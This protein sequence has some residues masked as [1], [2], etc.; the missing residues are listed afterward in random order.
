MRVELLGPVRAF[1]GA[2][3]VVLGPARQRAVFAALAVRAGRPVP[4]GD[5]VEA[6]WGPGAPASAAGGVHGY[7][8]RLRR[9]LEP[10]RAPR[11]TGTLLT[12]GP[13]GYTL[14]LAPAQIDAT[15][16]ERLIERARQDGQTVAW[17]DKALG[18]WHGEP[19]AGVP[20]PLAETERARLGEL[21]LTAIELRAEARANSGEAHGL[22]D[23]LAVFVREFPLRERIRE[24]QM[25][26]LY[27]CGRR[28]DALEAFRDARATLAEE[29]GVEP[30][31]ALRRLHERILAHDVLLKRP[32]TRLH[33]LPKKVAPRY[34][35]TVDRPFAGRVSELDRLRT[36]SSRVLSGHGG[37][38]W[39]E[40]DPG[41][42]K[43]ELIVR[44][45]GSV[46][47]RDVQV[48]W[49]VADELSNRVPLRVILD[50]LGIDSPGPGAAE[51]AASRVLDLVD[52]LCTRSP[53]I[54]VVDAMEWADE[55]SVLVWHRLAAATATRPL[56]LLSA[57]RP[58]PRGETLTRL[59][60]ALHDD[61]LELGP[62]AFT[63][64]LTLHQ[65]LIGAA[66]GPRLQRLVEHTPG[67]PRYLIALSEALTDL[68]TENGVS[69][70]R[71]DY[72][73]PRSLLETVRRDFDVLSHEALR[74][75]A[76]LGDEFTLSA[77]ATLTR[78][79]PSELITVF[80][81]AGVIDDSG[82]RLAFRHPL[83]REACYDG[84]P[85]A[86]RAALHRQ[87]A[88]TPLPTETG[89]LGLI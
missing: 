34:R 82:A 89:E 54:L 20:G 59:R 41:V 74:W 15:V 10:G 68:K 47:G 14:K 3:E 21:R 88:E 46:R 2:G 64:A 4:I 58:V 16:F 7:I 17:L 70:L 40:G 73:T 69:E 78:K 63:E 75:G 33:V 72:V 86:T 27:L 32:K 29:L 8:S 51:D 36:M 31:I 55:A 42:G 12:N 24:L 85:V 87:L 43:S 62:L 35:T 67:N 22:P 79:R 38:A 18:M 28:S 77:I 6:V 61:V 25:L 66:A 39:V 11:S 80:E 76:L 53:V 13:A 48:G 19:L 60:R 65:N 57:A 45:L 84:I 1:R 52:D 9:A 50:C 49:A 30:G 81:E 71:D 26:T 83:F 44:A 5:L 56:L 23:E 37:V